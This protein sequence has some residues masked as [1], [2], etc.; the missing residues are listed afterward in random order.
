MPL[1]RPLC[2][3]VHALRTPPRMRPVLGPALQCRYSSWQGQRIAKWKSFEEIDAAR[4]WVYMF[5]MES[6][7]RGL[8]DV[9]YAR[10]SGPGGQNVNKLVVV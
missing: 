3:L 1:L 6:I 9:T 7:P 5:T 8:C 4:N 2:P 10:S